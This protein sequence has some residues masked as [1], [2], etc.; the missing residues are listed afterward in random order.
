VFGAVGSASTSPLDPNFV[1]TGVYLNAGCPGSCLLEGFINDTPTEIN[2]VTKSVTDSRGTGLSKSGLGSEF[3]SARALF[4]VFDVGVIV[5]QAANG[6]RGRGTAGAIAITG[7]TVE[8]LT[9]ITS[10]PGALDIKGTF[11]P[12]TISGND[13]ARIEAQVT[14]FSGA[15]PCLYPYRA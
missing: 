2:A 9:E 14:D 7:F 15:V 10:F 4:S 11:S 8:G 1:G 12:A 6:G 13:F 5:T 3:A